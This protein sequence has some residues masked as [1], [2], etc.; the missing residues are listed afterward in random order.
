[1][2]SLNVRSNVTDG[3]GIL[4]PLVLPNDSIPMVVPDELREHDFPG[5]LNK[6]LPHD[7][8][9][10]GWAPMEPSFSGT[11]SYSYF[12]GDTTLMSC[13]C[14]MDNILTLFVYF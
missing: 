8:Q 10:L 9:V 2:I 3:L 1:V 12:Y 7:I 6:I 13:N 11:Q 14:R 5:L 4:P